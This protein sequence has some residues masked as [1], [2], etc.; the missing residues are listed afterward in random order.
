MDRCLWTDLPSLLWLAATAE[1]NH[2]TTRPISASSDPRH[3]FGLV[4]ASS[5]SADWKASRNSG[6]CNFV[7]ALGFA[8]VFDD[9]W[10]DGCGGYSSGFVAR[11]S[12]CW[13]ARGWMTCVCV[14]PSV[15]QCICQS[16]C[17]S[18]KQLLQCFSIRI[19]THNPFLLN[20]MIEFKI[21]SSEIINTLGFDYVLLIV[22]S[23]FIIF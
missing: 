6:R 1:L 14:H 16:E 8:C 3:V 7:V 23:G 2:K 18:L 20:N 4:D 10:C 12:G 17:G 15:H 21:T 19:H 22:W 9:S 11:C 5:P 13:G